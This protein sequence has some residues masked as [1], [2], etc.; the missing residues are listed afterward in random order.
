MT[1]GQANRRES[2]IGS[3][4]FFGGGWWINFLTPLGRL[5]EAAVL[6]RIC[7]LF[8]EIKLVWF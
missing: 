7:V 3:L 1:A 2:S 6:I 8:Q 5:A 4:S